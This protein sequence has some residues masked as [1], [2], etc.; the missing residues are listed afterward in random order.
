MQT[1]HT[2]DDRGN[3][4]AGGDG[5]PRSTDAVSDEHDQGGFGHTPWGVGIQNRCSTPFVPGEKDAYMPCSNRR[6]EIK[7]RRAGGWYSVRR[8]IMNLFISRDR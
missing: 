4:E 3:A 5:A 2:S 8:V 6:P 1:I 7:I